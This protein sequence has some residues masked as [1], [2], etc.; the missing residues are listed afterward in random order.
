MAGNLRRGYTTQF[1]AKSK[2]EYDKIKEHI[3]PDGVDSMFFYD[4][5]DNIIYKS[6]S[7]SVGV[8]KTSKYLY[9]DFNDFQITVPSNIANGWGFKTYL[10]DD[11]DLFRMSP[12]LEPEQLVFFDNGANREIRSVITSGVG[13]TLA[14]FNVRDVY[15][16]P[17]P[18]VEKAQFSFTAGNMV[19]SDWRGLTQAALRL[20][21]T[22]SNFITDN[23]AR[24]FYHSN[25]ILQLPA[26]I[27]MTKS[28]VNTNYMNM[29]QSPGVTF[30][31]TVN[32]TGGK[33]Y[34]NVIVEDPTFFQV[35]LDDSDYSRDRVYKF[36]YITEYG[37][38]EIVV[39]FPDF[40]VKGDSDF[41]P[42]LTDSEEGFETSFKTW[43]GTE[44]P[45]KVF[46]DSDNDGFKATLGVES[47]ILGWK[48]LA[49]V[50]YD[51][52]L[53]TVI[54]K[55]TVAVPHANQP[56]DFDIEGWTKENK[57]EII[58]QIRGFTGYVF[59]KSYAGLGY[60]YVGFRI[61]F[62]QGRPEF[63]P[64]KNALE[65]KQIRFIAQKE[66]KYDSFG[67]N[68]WFGKVVTTG[69]YFEPITDVN[70]EILIIGGG[71]GG[72]RNAQGCG[73]GGGGGGYIHLTNLRFK[74]NHRYRIEV[75]AGG[76]V[77]AR[78]KP[79]FIKDTTIN[80]IIV[81]AG[82]GVNGG[83]GNRYD[84]CV[85]GKGGDVTVWDS[86]GELQAVV[87]L[88][89]RGGDGGTYYNFDSNP[90]VHGVADRVYFYESISTVTSQENYDLCSGGGSGAFFEYYQNTG[91]IFNGENDGNTNNGASAGN[92][93]TFN[94]GG[95]SAPANRGGGG[96]GSGGRMAQF[97]PGVV[98][99]S[100]FGAGNGGSGYCYIFFK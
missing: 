39:D 58:D 64:T 50:G 16:H 32:I 19:D 27:N 77:N 67:G 90:G 97:S 7:P 34:Q 10:S 82:G 29:Y 62:I 71:G 94:G 23:S 11:S 57:W 73:G 13:S 53:Q 41:V 59:N 52:N 21:V 51:Y 100:Y 31:Q 96:G 47:G 70:A 54:I 9:K 14:D 6:I 1:Y 92:G 93:S 80:K 5:E 99:N 26:V 48:D 43:A 37:D 84:N 35:A 76:A 4:S 38:S 17:Y 72:G 89:Q 2:A 15:L 85:G 18:R 20:R 63:D 22:G 78:G 36:H 91:V 66:T 33:E 40:K 81:K 69:Q 68:F 12:L 83:N 56:Y 75:G 55:N 46:N 30:G 98:S 8:Y 61:N 42:I 79:S 44:A 86:D 95:S 60:L 24:L 49:N 74:K 65:I 28:G 3:I 25:R 88:M 87:G 45:W